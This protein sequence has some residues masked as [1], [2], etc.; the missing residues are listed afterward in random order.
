MWTDL[1]LDLSGRVGGG[2]I[3]SVCNKKWDDM[4]NCYV[5]HFVLMGRNYTSSSIYQLRR[6]G[7]SVSASHKKAARNNIKKTTCGNHMTAN[8]KRNIQVDRSL[9]KD[10]I[11]SIWIPCKG[12]ANP[13]SDM[14]LQTFCVNSPRS[15]EWRYL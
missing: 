7:R 4:V 13:V 12:G 11:N 2:L 6:S 10:C 8:S 3:S 5:N 15:G 1:I 9:G 14:I